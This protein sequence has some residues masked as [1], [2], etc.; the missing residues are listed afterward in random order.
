VGP[1]GSSASGFAFV[2]AKSRACLCLVLRTGHSGH[3]DDGLMVELDDLSG[4]FQ[5][6]GFHHHPTAPAWTHCHAA[7]GHCPR[8][9][10]SPA[11]RSME[12]PNPRCSGSSCC[13]C[14]PGGE[15]ESWRPTG[16]DENE[17]RL[18]RAEIRCQWQESGLKELNPATIHPLDV[19][20]IMPT[21]PS[22]L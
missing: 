4:L 20:W 11:S 17:D 14:K 19:T 8:C 16:T 2:G 3:G 13:C 5:P 1:E 10:P 15:K 6:Q 9:L 22:N 7:R 21:L 12:E 18:D